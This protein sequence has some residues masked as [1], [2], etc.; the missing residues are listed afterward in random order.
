MGSNWC[1]SCPSESCTI[2][3]VKVSKWTVKSPVKSPRGQ[4][5]LVSESHELEPPDRDNNPISF[6]KYLFHQNTDPL[7]Y[8]KGYLTLSVVDKSNDVLKTISSEVFFD[9]KDEEEQSDSEKK[10]LE[11]I[12]AMLNPVLT[13]SSNEAFY[14]APESNNN[15]SPSLYDISKSDSTLL[16]HCVT[17]LATGERL[18]RD[19]ML[20]AEVPALVKNMK[21]TIFAACDMIR[22]ARDRKRSALKDFMAKQLLV[23][24]APQALYRILNKLGISTCNETVRLDSIVKE[25]ANFSSGFSFAG[26]KFSLLM[27]LYDNIGF[28]RR[29]GKT[30]GVGY[31]QF[32]ALQIIEIKKED[33]M[34]WGVYPK[35]SSEGEGM[36][37]D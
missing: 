35:D 21:M 36:L 37:S 24:A 8:E 17:A 1:L 11:I 2:A 9:G 3:N 20:E 25:R 28:R 7:L 12:F 29:G 15:S 30:C 10:K 18:K 19:V 32:T 27:M 31:D 23:H 6:H 4:V 26:K 34:K 13:Q 33:L 16:Y 5:R 22:N 14:I